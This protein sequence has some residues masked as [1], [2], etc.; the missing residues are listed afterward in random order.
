MAMADSDLKN[1]LE[2]GRLLVQEITDHAEKLVFEVGS[3]HYWTTYS[4]EILSKIRNIGQNISKLLEFCEQH[5]GEGNRIFQHNEALKLWQTS[6]G[7]R[8]ALPPVRAKY[9]EHLSRRRRQRI[10]GQSEED[11]VSLE[12]SIIREDQD[13]LRGTVSEVRELFGNLQTRIGKIP[14]LIGPPKVNAAP[15][16]NGKMDG[17]EAGQESPAKDQAKDSQA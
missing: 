2:E 6:L 7:L 3:A 1:L 12:P 10:M 4:T 13:V 16:A 9:I 11:D 14:D 15:A 8:Q 5:W 17:S